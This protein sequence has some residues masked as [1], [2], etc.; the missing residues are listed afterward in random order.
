MKKYT[1]LLFLMLFA[2]SVTKTYSQ[3]TNCASNYPSATQTIASGANSTI[4]TCSF[5]GDYANYSVVSG[6]TYT[7]STCGS[8]GFD[9]QLTLSQGSCGSGTVLGYNDDACG[10]QST[11]TWTATFTGTVSVLV[12]QFNCV[13]NS[14]CETVT[15]SCSGPPPPPPSSGGDDCATA[16]PFCTGTTYT[17][18]NN[19]GQPSLGANGIYDCLY[20]TPNPV[21]YFMEG[22]TAG[23]LSIGINQG[24]TAGAGNLDVDYCLWGPF[25]SQAAGCAGLSASNVLSCSY[26]AS[27]TE[28]ANIPNVIIGQY[29]I[30]LLTNFSNSAG[31]IQ[32][33][34]SAGPGSTNCAVLC[35]MS[36]LTAL[37]G[38]CVPATNTFSVTGQVTFVYPPASGNLVIT[39][40]CGGSVTIP[41]AG[42]VSP[43]SY[44]LTGLTATG[45]AC[46][47]TAGF[48]ADLTCALTQPYTSPTACNA[49][50]ATASNTGSYCAGATIQLNATGGGTYS[51]S[52]PGGFTSI[53]QNP[54]IA[55]ST[56]AMSGTYT[57]T[58]TNGGTCTATTIV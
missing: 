6:S 21:W 57:V 17:F 22:A 19:T 11:I 29:Y 25:S 23:N 50:V 45:G 35:G 3:C 43:Y 49:C 53:L 54:T 18:P 28:T 36:D 33:S 39:S 31:V 32:F 24:T 16:I 55:A 34:Q 27:P 13:T 8:T 4:T 44:T 20:S 52:G 26:S 41:S 1:F 37:P 47:V 12:S 46:T 38:A 30:L 2:F 10:I 42:L 51:W 15:W 58:V 9:T 56:T 48:T 7:W 14:T 40:S 5:G